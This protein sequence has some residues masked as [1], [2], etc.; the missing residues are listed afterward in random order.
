MDEALWHRLEPMLDD[1]LDLG[2]A[3]RNTYL[4]QHCHDPELRA[5]IEHFLDECMEVEGFLNQDTLEMAKEKALDRSFQESLIDRRFGP[6]RT[7]EI[8]GR[9][10]MGTVLLANRADGHFEQQVAVKVVG[11][12]RFASDSLERFRFERQI[13]ADLEHPSIAKLLDGG[14]GEDGLPYLVMDYVRGLPL[15]QFVQDSNPTLEQRL[16]LLIE[17]CAAIDHAHRRRVA[18]LDLKPSNILVTEDGRPK[19]LDFGIAQMLDRRDSVVDGSSSGRMT[20]HY[21]APEQLRGE[22]VTSSCDVYSLGVVLFQLLTGRLPFERR[23]EKSEDLIRR[24][25]EHEPPRPSSLAEFPHARELDAVVAKALMKSPTERYGS[26]S[27]FADDLR[28]ILEKKPVRALPPTRLYLWN[29]HVQRH[30][31]GW[32]AGCLV[33]ISVTALVLGWWRETQSARARIEVARDFARETERIES[34]LRYAYALPSHDVSREKALTEKRMANI[35]SQAQVLGHIAEGSAQLAL[36]RAHLMM[37]RA[38]EAK[39]HLQAAWDSGLTSSEVAFALGKS[40]GEIYQKERTSAS[41]IRDSKLR[42][43]EIERLRQI[44]RDP[45]VELLSRVEETSEIASPSLVAAMIALLDERYEEALELARQA[46]DETPWLPEG[47]R[48]QGE[49]WR[50]IA[51]HHVGNGLWLEAVDAADQ[52]IVALDQAARLAPSDTQI[53][54]ALCDAHVTRSAPARLRR[55]PQDQTE[56]RRRCEQAIALDPGLNHSRLQLARMYVFAV[57]DP[58]LP[59]DDRLI[60]LEAG[61]ELA[62]QALMFS[63]GSPEA[64]TLLGSAYLTRAFF[65]SRAKGEDPR[66][67]LALAAKHLENAAREDPGLVVAHVNRGTA[68]ALLAEERLARGE[69]P[70][71]AFESAI[72]SFEEALDRSPD[73]GVILTNLGNLLFNRA[74]FLH[75]QGQE[76]KPQLGRA[77]EICNR[78]LEVNPELNQTLNLKG[79]VLEAF[80]RL[81]LAGGNQD[82]SLFDRSKAA[83]DQAREINPDFIVAW[84]NEGALFL[85]RAHADLRSGRDPTASLEASETS[86]QK[87]ASLTRDHNEA[88]LSNMAETRLFANRLLRVQSLGSG[89]AQTRRIRSSLASLDNLLRKALAVDPD[90]PLLQLRAAQLE[91]E[92][93]RLSNSAAEQLAGLRQA[94]QQLDSL[95]SARSTFAQAHALAV[96]VMLWQIAIEGPSAEG[97]AAA[98]GHLDALDSPAGLFASDLPSLEVIVR[99]LH[100]PGFIP[101]NRPVAGDRVRYAELSELAAR[102]NMD[103]GELIRVPSAAGSVP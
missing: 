4:N 60:Q 102:L 93:V 67:D 45:A 6:Y 94:E 98:Q 86:L 57:Q 28:R 5:E 35:R 18:H 31:W 17:I 24:L 97:L 68:M 1:L 63:P 89:A 92:K 69:D 74:T 99:R 56:G 81:E 11:P 88:L 103:A 37:H 70:D 96:E 95:L 100:D 16:E 87:A 39:A 38:R 55:A 49:A 19:I 48:L 41:Q 71:P 46:A 77:L 32:V 83:L 34:F 76:T 52:A 62:Q 36:G 27:G 65:L 2:P 10:G 53:A 23:E 14:V 50:Q 25:T 72:R 22:A 73:H 42:A 51:D 91:L 26:A 75:Q 43:L 54:D 9:G 80:F 8:L 15:D 85:T 7:I 58:S 30:R 101:E 47:L 79:A 66:D 29:K 44:Y 12:R 84:I 3:D 21:A 82:L 61:L 13:L 90:S 78:S 33:A 40:L 64:L 20:P 59:L